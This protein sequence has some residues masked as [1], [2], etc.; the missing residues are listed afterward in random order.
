MGLLKKESPYLEGPGH[1]FFTDDGISIGFS[2]EGLRRVD[3]LVLELYE[4]RDDLNNEMYVEQFGF[5]PCKMGLCFWIELSTPVSAAKLITGHFRIRL[6]NKNYEF[7][8]LFKSRYKN[9][10]E[11]IECPEK[12]FAT[13][14]A[15]REGVKAE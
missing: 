10:W 3:E 2:I 7:D 8:V 15:P 12:V 11:L 13:V 4:I 5:G 14:K 1:Q 6:S 9:E